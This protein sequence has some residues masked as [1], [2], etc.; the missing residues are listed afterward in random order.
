[1]PASGNLA[2]T[3]SVPANDVMD[4]SIDIWYPGAQRLSLTLRTRR[5]PV[6][7]WWFPPAAAA[8]PTTLIHTLAGGNVVAID[9][10][11]DNVQNHDN[12]ILIRL[13]RG[14]AA[15]I[16]SGTWRITL[17]NAGTSP[18]P[19]DAWIE[20]PVDGNPVWTGSADTRSKSVAIPASAREAIAVGCYRTKT[21]A[22]ADAGANKGTL[23]DF[24]SR[25]PTRDGRIKPDLSA[26]GE[27]VMSAMSVDESSPGTTD[28][29][30]T[31]QLMAGTSMS[32]P[33]VAGTVALILEKNPTLRQEG[34][35]PPGPA[36][37]RPKGRTDWHR[38]RSAQQQLGSRQARY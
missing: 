7:P 13:M 34:A 21:G 36:G 22:G 4:D 33:M 32:T 19:F 20:R 16:A 23:S 5:A 3:F 25:G 28:A 30:G 14:T 15:S 11:I 10:R 2:Q 6:H 37:H 8:A 12:E 24:S 31:Y 26:P 38:Q 17:T 29:S 27:F 35:D 1:M 18:V 9:S